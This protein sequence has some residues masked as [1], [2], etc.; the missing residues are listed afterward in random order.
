MGLLVDKELNGLV[1]VNGSRSKWR[2]VMSNV[3]QGQVSGLVVF[4][5]F[6]GDA[7]SGIECP[8]RKFADNI[9]LP[10]AIDRLEG[11]DLDRPEVGLC[12][13]QQGQV[14]SPAPRL[15]KSQTQT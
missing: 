3:P 8:L 7:D 13:P 12:E 1:A 15:G 2:P 11:R 9:K 14:Q 5:I 10:G 6:V 4:N